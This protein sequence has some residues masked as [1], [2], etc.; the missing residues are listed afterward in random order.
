MNQGEVNIKD[1]LSACDI[2][3]GIGLSA[4]KAIKED[5]EAN[6]VEQLAPDV[7][8]L[9]GD[10]ANEVKPPPTDDTR[11]LVVYFSWADNCIFRRKRGCSDIAQC[12]SAR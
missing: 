8:T 3:A 12:G 10:G 2:A 11:I 7:S 9:L 4:C 5:S 1:F 6:I